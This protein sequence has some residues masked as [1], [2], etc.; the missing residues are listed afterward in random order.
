MLTRLTPVATL[1]ATKRF[2][3]LTGMQLPEVVLYNIFL[4][5]RFI[6][7]SDFVGVHVPKDKQTCFFFIL[8]DCLCGG[9]NL[10]LY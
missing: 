7:L 3:Y 2:M 4:A 9:C 1:Y 6:V 5:K 8:A 10:S